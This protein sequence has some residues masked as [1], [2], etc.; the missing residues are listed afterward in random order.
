[1]GKGVTKGKRKNILKSQK[2]VGIGS[3]WSMRFGDG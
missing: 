2:G 3:E 1:M